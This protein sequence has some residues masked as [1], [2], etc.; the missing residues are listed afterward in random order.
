MTRTRIPGWLA[1]RLADV[2]AQ[3]LARELTVTEGAAL[4]AG[5]IAADP[6]AT[7]TVAAGYAAKRLR[8]LAKATTARGGQLDLFPDLRGLGAVLEVSVNKFRPVAA[9]TGADWDGALRQIETKERNAIA[10][11]DRVRAAYARVRLRLAS[12]AMTTA[13]VQARVHAGGP[14]TPEVGP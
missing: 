7:L 1:E 2:G 4:L 3:V 12:P 14:H 5:E 9:M 8:Q 11:A 10:Q 13:D 6:G